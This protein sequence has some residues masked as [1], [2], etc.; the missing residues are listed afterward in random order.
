MIY[1]RNVTILKISGEPSHLL[2][3]LLKT[4]NGKVLHDQTESLRHNHIYKNIFLCCRK[5]ISEAGKKKAEAVLGHPN[6][7]ERM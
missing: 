2:W 6:Q 3:P 1:I 4:R 5:R 7:L